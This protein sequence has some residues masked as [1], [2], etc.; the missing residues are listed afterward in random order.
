MLQKGLSLAAKRRNRELEAELQLKPSNPAPA[1]YTTISVKEYKDLL[2][3]RRKRRSECKD[4][5]EKL[6]EEKAGRSLDAKRWKA[7]K[8]GMLLLRK[9]AS[10]NHQSYLKA[11]LRDMEEQPQQQ[12]RDDDEKAKKAIA[13]VKAKY[14]AEKEV[15]KDEK[16]QLKKQRSDLRK[17]MEI[18]RSESSNARY[19]DTATQAMVDQTLEAKQ[20]LEV[21]IKILDDSREHPVAT[22]SHKSP[23]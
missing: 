21:K 18:L 1:D 16:R 8:E 23:S 4:L 17:E 20:Q 10:E 14:A 9:A 13:D 12:R 3:S 19:G 5:E 15:W 7:E 2:D 11:R 6:E 22:I